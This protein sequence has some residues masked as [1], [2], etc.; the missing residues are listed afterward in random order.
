[1]H[2]FALLLILV[3][4]VVVGCGPAPKSAEDP[5]T[6]RTN[7][8]GK[9]TIVATTGMVA[10]VVK[11][12]GGDRVEVRTLMGPGVDPHLYKASPGDVSA[13]QAAD[14]VFYTGLFLEG[15]L[16]EVLSNLARSKPVV[17][18]GDAVPVADRLTEPGKPDVADPH[19]WFD[20]NLWAM[21]VGPVSE[22]LVKLDPTHA[23]EYTRR[24]EEKRAEILAVAAEVKAAL[25]AVPSGQ[26][27]LVTAHDAFH[28]F[29]RAF[30]F[31][32]RGVQG[33]STE[34]EAGL[35]EVNALVDLLVS[36]RIKAVFIE[37][38]VSDK[39][40]RAL[41]EGARQRGADVALGGSLFSDAMGEPGTESG[42]YRGMLLHNARTIADALR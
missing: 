11:A 40:V 34:S 9:L 18:I 1:M 36:R 35:R 16:A 29:G 4:S 12:V 27:V 3:V 5:G 41:I 19:V 39:N 20:P 21:T 38:T 28:Y 23:E 32:V 37:T 42:T 33:I 22:A 10:D 26:R 25:A 2:R 7:E 17:A 15:K 31:E 14:A 13:L 6:A 30:E 8:A 24:A